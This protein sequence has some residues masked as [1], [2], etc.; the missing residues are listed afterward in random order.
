[1]VMRHLRGQAATDWLAGRRPTGAGSGGRY[2]LK[3]EGAGPLINRLARFEPTVYRILKDNIRVAVTKVRDRAQSYEPTA[4]ALFGTMEGEQVSRGWGVWTAAKDGRDLGF[5][6]TAVGLRTGMKVRVRQIRRRNTGASGSTVTGIRGQ[7]DAPLTPAA[8]I[9]LLAGSKNGDLTPGW[10]GNF[11]H[12]LNRRYGT[13][14]PRGMTTA[15]RELGPEAGDKIDRE[16]ERA[17]DAI[18]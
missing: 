9:F 15:W 11:N 18:A 12:E 17:K 8:A 6:G 5:D 13:S 7:V 3:V 14:Y 16:L 10:G 2:D 1:M 4:A